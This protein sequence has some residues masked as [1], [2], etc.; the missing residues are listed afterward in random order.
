M[1]IGF[2]LAYDNMKLSVSLSI[3]VKGCL[4]DFSVPQVMGILNLTPDSFYV[5]SRMQTEVEITNRVEQIIKDGASIIDIGAYS[6]RP[7]CRAYHY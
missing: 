3:N 1:R 6:S 2:G 5:G 7:K 4:L